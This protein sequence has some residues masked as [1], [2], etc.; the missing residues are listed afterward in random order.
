MT[1]SIWPGIKQHTQKVLEHS[2]WS[3]GNGDNILFWTDKWLDRVVATHWSIPQNVSSSLTMKVSACVSNGVWCL[4]GYLVDKDPALANQICQI[5]LPTDNMPDMLCWDSAPDGILTSKIAFQ[6]LNGVGQRSTWANILWNSHIP[7]SRSF[8][9]WRLLHNKL[10]TNE[11]LRKSGCTI[12]S[13]CCFCLQEFESSQHIFFEC[14]VT[15]RLWEWLGKGT[16]Q[17]LDCSNCL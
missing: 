1:S 5:T 10:P 9:T 8:I 7:P 14:S 12:V 13:I 15:S 17:Q 2:S 11:N 6:T 16:N 4:P 3:V